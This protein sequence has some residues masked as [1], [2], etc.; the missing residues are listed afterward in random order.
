MDFEEAYQYFQ[1]VNHIILNSSELFQWLPNEFK[2]SNQRDSRRDIMKFKYFHNRITKP[3]FDE[4]TPLKLKTDFSSEQ[5]NTTYQL[6][7]IDFPAI[8]FLIGETKD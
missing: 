1:N 2:N 5:H 3:Y 4:T 8:L 6:N 7:D